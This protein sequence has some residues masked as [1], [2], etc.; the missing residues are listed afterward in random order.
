MDEKRTATYDAFEEKL[1]TELIKLCTESG[2]MDRVLLRTDD[3]DEEKTV[4]FISAGTC[5]GRVRQSKK[6]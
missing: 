5:N 2:M 4:V 1:R 3:I 6:R